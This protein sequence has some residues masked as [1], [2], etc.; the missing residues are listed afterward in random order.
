MTR[1]EMLKWVYENCRTEEAAI[2][3][4]VLKDKIGEKYYTELNLM[5]FI[6][7]TFK[8]GEAYICLSYMGRTYCE[9]LLN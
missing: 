6:K 1:K 9:E 4:K 5:Q 2:H 8:S 3:H 7:R